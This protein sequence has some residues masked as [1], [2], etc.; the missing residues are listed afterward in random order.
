MELGLFVEPQVGGSYR[1]LVNLAQ[2]AES[3]GLDVFA[4][5]DHYLN[6]DESADT[7]D[8]LAAL[9]GVAVETSSI[10]LSTLVS[11]LT[12]RHP[13]VMAKSATTID[14]ISGGRFT[15]GVGTGW[16]ESEHLAFGLDLPP[17]AERFERLEESL[18]YLRTA[19]EGGGTFRGDHYSLEAATVAPPGSA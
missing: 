19:F 7:T 14:E 16:M 15:L 10:R 13:A 17:M 12:F 4:R 1:E 9:A 11:P 18:Q 8:A 2:W 6:G 5:S 3:Q